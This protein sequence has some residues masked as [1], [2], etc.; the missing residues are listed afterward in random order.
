MDF[1]TVDF[2]TSENILERLAQKEAERWQ[3]DGIAGHTTQQLCQ[4]LAFPPGSMSAE[5]PG[6]SAPGLLRP[7]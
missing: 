1:G 5:G 3:V 6:G 4:Y 7:C 2:P